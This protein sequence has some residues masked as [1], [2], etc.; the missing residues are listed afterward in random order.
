MLYP[1]LVVVQFACIGWHLVPQLSP[2]IFDGSVSEYLLGRAEASRGL[3]SSE[4]ESNSLHFSSKEK[5]WRKIETRCLQGLCIGCQIVFY[6]SGVKITFYYNCCGIVSGK[7]CFPSVP[8]VC[9]SQFFLTLS[10]VWGWWCIKEAYLWLGDVNNT[11]LSTSPTQCTHRHNGRL[12]TV[13]DLG[14]SLDTN[15]TLSLAQD[16]EYQ[17]HGCLRLSSADFI[18]AV[19]NSKLNFWK[20]RMGASDKSSRIIS[21]SRSPISSFLFFTIILIRSLPIRRDYD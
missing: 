10:M 15:C 3:V 2:L 7:V 4:N 9:R 16:R 18:S 21:I 12:H 11:R 19:L 5:L 14:L 20:I 17:I 13:T 1:N 8:S 6:L